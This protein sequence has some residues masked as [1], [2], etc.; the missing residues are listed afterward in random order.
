MKVIPKHC[1]ILLIGPRNSGQQE[2]LEKHFELNESI[3]PEDIFSEL[4]TLNSSFFDRMAVLAEISR[5]ARFR[6]EHG[7][8]TIINGTNLS[9]EERKIFINLAQKFKVPLFYFVFYKDFNERVVNF[10]FG[11]KK[12]EE[13]WKKNQKNIMLGDN[14]AEVI[15][16]ETDQFKIAEEMPNSSDIFEHLK[17]QGF[18]GVT[19]LAD[20]HAM[21]ESLISAIH[22]AKLRNHFLISLGDLIDYGPNPVE[23][24][25]LV[26]QEVIRGRMAVTWGNHENKIHKWI[27]NY[28]SGDDTG[29]K[30]S[31]SQKVTINEIK[32]LN[33][34]ER[35]LFI[36]KWQSIMFRARHYW[37]I[38]NIYLTHGAFH[39]EYWDSTEYPKSFKTFCLF[40]QT[41]GRRED[42]YPNRIYNWCDSVPKDN[43]VIVGHDIRSTVSPHVVE[44]V[45]NGK[46]IFLDC[47]C[48][49]GG[50][51][52]TVDIPFTKTD[53]LLKVNSFC[54]H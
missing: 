45:N 41:E 33:S 20:V 51:L 31:S 30:L 26:Y 54:K 17:N 1:L 11:N 16:V 42:G 34:Y 4:G 24:I 46:I 18:S 13:I 37:I 38:K 48:G 15:N 50:N 14:V 21:K 2:F 29:L 39:P 49:K 19:V 12:E 5:R 40:G 35:N 10:S 27:K 44:N 3:S 32:S 6:L 36:N 22:W 43:I 9:S 47:G 28:L 52:Y 53:S 23:V 7:K 25:D 8:R